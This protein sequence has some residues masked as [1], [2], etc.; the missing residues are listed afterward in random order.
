M[1]LFLV[2]GDVQIPYYLVISNALRAVFGNLPSW[3][4]LYFAF[5]LGLSIAIIIGM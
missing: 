3:Y 1:I 2:L 4:P 5:G